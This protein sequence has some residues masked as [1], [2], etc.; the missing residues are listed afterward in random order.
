MLLAHQSMWRRLARRPSW[1]PLASFLLHNELA[2]QEGRERFIARTN[3]P[4]WRP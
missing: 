2:K 4:L 1:R 3:D